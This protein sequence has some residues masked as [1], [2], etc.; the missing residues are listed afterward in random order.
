MTKLKDD[1]SV[2]YRGFYSDRG[3]F[4]GFCLKRHRTAHKLHALLHSGQSQ[5]A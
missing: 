2:L 4:T 3:A 1:N 5:L